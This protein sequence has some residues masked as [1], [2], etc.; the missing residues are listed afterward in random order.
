MVINMVS[1]LDGKVTTNSGKAGSIGS[2]VDRLIMRSLRSRVDAVMI[3]AST[4]R[5]E[6]L[7][8]SVPEDL[9]RTRVSQGREPQPLAVLVSASGDLPLKENLLGPSPKD[10]LVFTVPGI[11]GECLATLSQLALVET[12]PVEGDSI[13]LR[14]ALHVLKARHGVTV[15]LVE[16][17]PSLNYSL[18]RGGLVDEIFLTLAPKLTGGQG[19][20]SPGILHGPALPPGT[21]F[22]ADL[23]SIHAAHGELFLRYHLKN[24]KTDPNS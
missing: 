3:G 13:D 11:P 18:V 1:S 21:D 23:L 15:L 8:L 6:K 17:G 7:N 24:L 10:R 14:I 20:S 5:A 19:P 12:L 4:L 16:G 22:S 2:P 9:S